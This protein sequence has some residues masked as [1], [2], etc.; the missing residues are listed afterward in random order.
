MLDIEILRL[1]WW[2]LI[3]VLLT[4]FAVTDG[5]DF[6]AAVLLPLVARNETE[7]RIVLNSIGPFWEGNQVWIIL[8]AGAL[9]AAWPFVYAVAFSGF[10]FLIL[11]LLLTMGISRPVSFKYRSKLPNQFWRRFW[12]WVV[13]AG[14]LCPA[15]IFGIL[16]GNVL[17][18]V[19]FYFDEELRITY[20]GTF[21]DLFHPFTWLCGITSLAMLV[22]HGGLYLGI[23]TEN[24]IRDRAIF[25]SRI[26]ALALIILFAI[27][28]IWV[29]YGLY[30]YETSGSIDPFGD[31]N[32]IHKAVI[33][34]VGAW[35]DNYT[36]YPFAMV[37]PLLGF[38]G[39]LGALLTARWGSSR[40]AFICSSL[41][42]IGIIATVGV[43]MFPFILP[44]STHVSSSLLVWDAS[45]SRL[46]LLMM[47]F[48]VVIF[49]PI[50]LL[51]TSWVYYALRGKVDKESIEHDVN[52]SAY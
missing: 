4:G 8:G 2:L 22:M 52:H 27:G 37:A 26:A 50:I 13:F 42:I 28:G 30:G 33:P 35:L 1:I 18:G 51:Y 19:P 34:K 45:S 47:L 29:A 10:Y 40:F 6:G 17:S 16:V 7:K 14:G 24:A 15:L 20:S 9:F 41:S 31:S 39:A 43:S 32:P 3:G 48:A 12:D 23:K 11:L 46:T 5:F 49:M 21:I 25:W 38:I 36:R 44:S